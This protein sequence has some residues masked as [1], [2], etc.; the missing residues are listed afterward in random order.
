MKLKLVP[1]GAET[2][3]DRAAEWAVR[4]DS[5]DL[6]DAEFAEFDEWLADASN[7]EAFDKASDAMALFDGLDSDLPELA[8]LREEAQSHSASPDRR[9][10]P[11]AGGALAAS[12][13]AA[14]LFFQAGEVSE[15]LPGAPSQVVDA[16]TAPLA[17]QAVYKTVVGEQRTVALADGSKVT[18]NTGTEIA[19]DYSPRERI[20]RLV[21]G[22]ALFDVAHAADRPFSVIVAGRKVTALGTLFEVR[23]D[24]NRLRVT[25]LRGRVRVDEQPAATAATKVPAPTFLSPGEQFSLAT[26]LAP[27]VQSVDVEQQLLWRQSLVEFDD[28]PIGDAIAELNRYSAKPIVVRDPR[29]ADMRISGIVKTGDADSFTAL[30]GAMLP[31]AA[32][33]NERGEVELYHTP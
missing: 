20:V 10:V 29:V 30:V 24:Q 22:Q 6:D 32:R 27:V 15:R 5:R 4:M 19:V 33:K 31:V 2:P 13:A 8:A 3:E 12:I 11:W 26:G 25:L 7:Q 14:L 16:G 28:A 23:L 1:G 17:G 21:R 18:L 9:W